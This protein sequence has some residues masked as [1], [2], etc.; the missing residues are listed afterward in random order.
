M[1]TFIKKT[2]EEYSSPTCE[3]LEIK[4]EGIICTSMGDIESGGVIG[5]KQTYDFIHSDSRGF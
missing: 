2:K 1:K 3:V 4:S 5:G